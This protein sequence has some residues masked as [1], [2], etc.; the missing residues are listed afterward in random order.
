MRGERLGAAAQQP[1]EVGVL[2]L[3]RLLALG[4]DAR[5]PLDTAGTE[6]PGGERVADLLPVPADGVRVVRLDG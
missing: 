3:V 4:A 2:E 1:V 6:L 5:V